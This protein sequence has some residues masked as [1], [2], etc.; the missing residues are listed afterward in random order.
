[1][2]EKMKPVKIEQSSVAPKSKSKTN[3][4]HTI[5]LS[6]ELLISAMESKSSTKSKDIENG[7]FTLF[8]DLLLPASVKMGND[9]IHSSTKSK[10][11]L[12]DEDFLHFLESTS[13][14]NF[15]QLSTFYCPEKGVS[16]GRKRK[17][18]EKVI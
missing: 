12:E 9:L 10:T 13:D 17:R 6:N 4:E 2:G 16:I 18:V 7:N 8:S 3:L 14:F 1:M 5:T 11:D 15:P